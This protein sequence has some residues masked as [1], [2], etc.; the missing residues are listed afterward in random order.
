MK[1]TSAGSPVTAEVVQ[2]VPATA[3]DA[4]DVQDALFFARAWATDFDATEIVVVLRGKTES[5][6]FS[7]YDDPTIALGM[8]EMG[9]CDVLAEILGLDDEGE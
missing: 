7:A 2:L 8:L 5:V 4:N 1:E 3:K 6:S 9:K